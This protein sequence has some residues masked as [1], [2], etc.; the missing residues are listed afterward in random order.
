MSDKIQGIKSYQVNLENKQKSDEPETKKRHLDGSLF[1]INPNQLGASAS[2][3]AS[4]DIGQ[5][6]SSGNVTT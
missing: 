1:N 2:I 6:L 3:I 5:R 4:N